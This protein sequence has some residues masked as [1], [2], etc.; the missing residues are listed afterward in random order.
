MITKYSLDSKVQLNKIVSGK[1]GN[2]YYPG[3]Y[4]KGRPLPEKFM[5]SEYVT[6]IEGEI[7]NSGSNQVEHNKSSDFAPI[8]EMV[9]KNTNP[10]A[11]KVEETNLTPKV[12]KPEVEDNTLNINEAT[13]K[14]IVDLEGIGYS[15]AKKVIELRELSPFANYS[16]LNER[17]PLAFGRDWKDFNLEF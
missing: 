15:T 8:E 12:I 13:R 16:D 1:T 2:L 3:V 14:Q 10:T 5:T 11:V 7:E 4:S 9:I 6:L 17:V